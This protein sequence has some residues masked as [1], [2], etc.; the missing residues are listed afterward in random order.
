MAQ[1]VERKLKFIVVGSDSSVD[2]MV[3]DRGYE[4]YTIAHL[5]N[6]KEY[7]G[8]IFTG[9]GD[10][11]PYLYG[12][13]LHKATS[14]DYGRDLRELAILRRV[15]SKKP[16]IGICRGGQL[17]NVYSGGSMWQDVDN[18][19]GSHKAICFMSGVEF[20]CPSMHHQIMRP[21]KEAWLMAGASVSTKYEDF[22]AE[23]HITNNKSEDLEACFYEH[24]NSYCYQG[25][26]EYGGYKEATDIFWDHL[27]LVFDNV[28]YPKE[29]AEAA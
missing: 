9:G 8:I 2:R 20:T 3:R 21:T 22:H 18:H 26:P 25:H 4:P 14:P 6:Q 10:I 15:P 11:N 12:Q 27:N 29:K 24:T 13:G 23:K 28:W 1:K 19:V 16:K 17:L 5:A 7:D